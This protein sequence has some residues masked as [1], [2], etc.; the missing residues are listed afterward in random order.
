MAGGDKIYD[1]AEALTRLDGDEALFK[2]MAEMF[3]GECESYCQALA[4]ALASR[5]AAQLRREAHTVKSLLATFSFEAGRQL[6]ARLE[7]LAAG[8]TIEGAESLTQDLI[9]AVRQLAA[10]LAADA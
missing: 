4:G 1:R 5:E 6:A 7:Q 3:V 8:G 2:E 10:A 9:V